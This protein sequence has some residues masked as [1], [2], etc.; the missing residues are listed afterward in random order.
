MDKLI[1]LEHGNI[2]DVSRGDVLNDTDI[3]IKGG[4]V[5]AI[6]N[7]EKP[8]NKNIQRID[9]AGK[10]ILPGLFDC[11]THLAVLT[12]REDDVKVDILRECRI[13]YDASFNLELE[14][15]VLNDF[16]K[17]GVTQVRDAGGPIAILK[18]LKS[19][20]D[21]GE[22]TGPDIFYAGPMLESS[23]LRAAGM[24][25]KWPGWTVAVD[26]TRDIDRI[27]MEL[28]DGGASLA[29]TF[30]KFDHDLLRYFL[31]KC[32]DYNLPVTNDPGPTFFHDV[33]VDI[34]LELGLTC[35]EHAKSLWNAVLKDEYRIEHDSLDSSPP[36]EMQNFV[37]KM[38]ETGAETID[39]EKLHDLIGKIKSKGAFV[40]PT[41]QVTKFYSEKPEIF[42]DKEPEKY[43][44]I[45]G[46]L[47]E[48]GRIITEE[49]TK[50]KVKLMVGQ[51][52]YIPR[53]TFS[54]MQ[55]LK[56]CGHSESEI[57][58]G[59]T[60]YP[61]EW[62]GVDD[63]YGS[64]KPGGVANLTILKNNPLSDIKNIR[65]VYGVIKAG[66]IVSMEMG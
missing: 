31:M 60:V 53:F 58:K 40:C 22:I 25:E 57:I 4:T 66:R 50:G 26:T 30:G 35:F 61:A 65:S 24:N 43:G 8:E 48:I 23:P 2:I 39:F 10:Y 52:G 17:R 42:N 16:V 44:K 29:K 47:Y 21:S 46:K 55:L 63:K 12:G 56:S 59:A 7:A 45:F 6:G 27:V 64:I 49:L 20:I 37:S 28:H 5:D 38:L 54:E 32:R 36:A 34:G 15:P 11:H 41:L 13:E 62:L 9:C 14:K 1:I 51:D 3:V 33:P 18:N 19:S